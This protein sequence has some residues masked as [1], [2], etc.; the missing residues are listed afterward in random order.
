MTNSTSGFSQ[1]LLPDVLR[2]LA[3]EPLDVPQWA[4]VSVPPDV[5]DLCGVWYWGPVAF[6]MWSVQNGLLELRPLGEGRESRFRRT[7]DETWV[8]LEGYYAGEPL[9]V[10]REPSGRASALN[11]ASLVFTRTPYDH[12]A[13]V[14]GGIDPRGWT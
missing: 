2:I 8:G 12:N 1:E 4:P 9:F 10:I 7:G 6:G 13:D 5:L 14:P 3:E 11:I